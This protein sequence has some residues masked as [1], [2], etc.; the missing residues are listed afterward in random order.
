M[1]RRNSSLPCKKIIDRIKIVVS[2]VSDGRDFT[3]TSFTMSHNFAIC[4]CK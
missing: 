3:T 1:N 4:K 2:L